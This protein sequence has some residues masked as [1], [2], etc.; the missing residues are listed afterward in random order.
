MGGY[1]GPS[2]VKSKVTGYTEAVDYFNYLS[3]SQKNTAIQQT[4]R[5]ATKQYR[6][7]LRV[8]T[9]KGKTG[10]IRGIKYRGSGGKPSKKLNQSIGVRKSK[11]YRGTKELVQPTWAGHLVKRGGRANHFVVQG[12]KAIKQDG[13]SL[14]RAS[15]KRKK[16]MR[17]ADKGGHVVHRK[18]VAASKP[19]PFVARTLSQ[20]EGTIFNDFQTHFIKAM[21]KEAKKYLKQYYKAGG[22]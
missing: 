17:F 5:I 8:N 20:K 18:E 7:A 11:R 3:S 16:Y 2:L 15:G 19:N 12:R 13:S 21:D 14:E 6:A 1:K 10:S 9:P 4:Y 22:I